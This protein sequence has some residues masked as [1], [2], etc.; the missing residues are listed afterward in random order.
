MTQADDIDTLN[1]ASMR[2]MSDANVFA[3]TQPNL[4]V[5]HKAFAI[6]CRAV[7]S[8]MAGGGEKQSAASLPNLLRHHAKVIRQYAEEE[9]QHEDVKEFDIRTADY[10]EQA[11]AALA[12]PSSGEFERGWNARSRP[13]KISLFACT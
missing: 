10:L 12:T 11:A 5:T 3:M 6:L 13:L 2:F 7:A 9:G 8:L 4:V 1:Q